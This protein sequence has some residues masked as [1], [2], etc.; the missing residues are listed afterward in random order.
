[1]VFFES[2]TLILLDKYTKRNSISSHIRDIVLRVSMAV[3]LK[4]SD[5]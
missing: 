2:Q 1:M 3:V 4:R 5:L